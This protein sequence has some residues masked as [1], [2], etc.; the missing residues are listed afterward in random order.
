MKRVLSAAIL[1]PLVLIVFIL[2]N[3]YVVD[4]FMGIVALRCIYELFHAF[5]QKGHASSKMGWIFS[6]NRNNVYTCYTRTLCKIRCN[7]NHS[8]ICFKS[9]SY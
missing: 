5:E 9:C 6:S 3:T 2:G 7:I 1:L 8:N 4:V